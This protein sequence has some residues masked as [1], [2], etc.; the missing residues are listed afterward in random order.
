MMATLFL[1][2]GVPMICGGDELSI[3]HNGNNNTY[4][5]D[6]ELNYFHWENTTDEEEFL[7]FLSKLSCTYPFDAAV[8]IYTAHRQARTTPTHT[9]TC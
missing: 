2:L 1:S 7:V 4:C 9:H 5:Q 8:R 3:T 6:N